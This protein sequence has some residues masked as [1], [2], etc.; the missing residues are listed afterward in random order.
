MNCMNFDISE[1]NFSERIMS[2]K[3]RNGQSR[4]GSSR[5][6]IQAVTGCTYCYTLEFNY[7]NGKRINNLAPKFVRANGTIEEETPVTDP[8]SKMYAH[9]PQPVFTQEIFEDCGKAF[10]AALLDLIEDNPISRI[11]LSCYRSVKNVRDDIIA[12]LEKYQA[13][14]PNVIGASNFAPTNQKVAKS[15]QHTF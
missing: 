12:N 15:Y 10:G 1:C 6:A 7:H 5:V 13:G 4:E 14:N 3:D 9:N 8:G 2:L 11:P